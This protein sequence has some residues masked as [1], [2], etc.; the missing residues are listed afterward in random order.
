MSRSLSEV[1]LLWLNDMVEISSLNTQSPMLLGLKSLFLYSLL[2]LLYF[3]LFDLFQLIY[4]RWKYFPSVSVLFFH[5]ISMLIQSSNPS[6]LLPT[7]LI[8]AMSITPLGI[9]FLYRGLMLVFVIIL[10]ETVISLI[11]SKK[12][13]A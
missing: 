2:M 6:H 13:F 11:M 12:D 5:A 7:P 8:L 4:N 1:L 3:T 9:P 10:M